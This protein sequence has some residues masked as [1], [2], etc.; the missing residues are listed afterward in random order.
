MTLPRARIEMSALRRVRTRFVTRRNALLLFAVV[1]TAIFVFPFTLLFAKDDRA[2]RR[3]A[4][5]CS[6][7]NASQ[8][9]TGAVRCEACAHHAPSPEPGVLAR[10]P[11]RPLPPP[12]SAR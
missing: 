3:P 9:P 1:M 10:P 6:S 7:A 4:V 2:E 11:G 8:T 12:R 5:K